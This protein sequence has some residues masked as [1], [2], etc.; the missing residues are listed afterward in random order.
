MAYSA[1]ALSFML[2]NLGKPV[3]F[4]GSQIP[5]CDPHNDARRNVLASILVAANFDLPEVCLFF[6]DQLYRGNRSTKRSTSGMNAFESPNFPALGDLQIGFTMRDDLLLP[7]PRGRMQC[8]SDLYGGVTVLRLVPGFDDTSLE[9]I[10]GSQAEQ[11]RPGAVVLQLYGTGGAPNTKARMYKAIQD[12]VEKGVIVVVGSQCAFG[13]VDLNVY[14][15]SDGLLRS[16]VISAGDMTVEA[17]VGKLA[18][19]MG[20]EDLSVEQRRAGFVSDLRGERSVVN[21]VPSSQRG[22]IH[23]L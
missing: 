19:L 16:G 21:T 9:M 6:N 1:A 11:D 15:V 12:A 10:L 13:A 18:Y 14:A 23:H 8:H 5:F 3:V 17:V 7:Q 4:T 2:R 20:R 22:I